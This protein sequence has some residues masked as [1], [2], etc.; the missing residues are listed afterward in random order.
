VTE[1]VNEHNHRQPHSEKAEWKEL[2]RP[3]CLFLY[4]DFCLS[5]F[6]VL[7]MAMLQLV[8]P[9]MVC[10]IVTK[11]DEQSGEEGG[12]SSSKQIDLCGRL[13]QSLL[14]SPFVRI[15]NK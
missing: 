8:L 1:Q 14:L 7:L 10:V 2:Y 12:R 6:Q 3:L 13:L 9:T 4:S 11:F 5:R 15:I